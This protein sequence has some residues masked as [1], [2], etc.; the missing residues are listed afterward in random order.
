[1]V[2]RGEEAL[3]PRPRWLRA[4]VRGVRKSYL[5]PPLDR[6]RELARFIAGWLEDR[7]DPVRAP[8]VR[9]MFIVPER[10]ADHPRWPV[11][12]LH[13]LG[14]LAELLVLEPR[15]LDWLADVKRLER[16]VRD[17]RLRNYRYSWI[18]RRGGAP[19]RLIE[20]PKQRLKEIQRGLLRLI[21]E[22][23]PPHDAAH[24]FVRGRSARTHAQA[25]VGKRVVLRL[26]LE[27]FFASVQAPRIYGIFRTAGYPE[28]VAHSLTALV[29][30][31]VPAH[32]LAELP[33]S[34]DPAQWRMKNRL[35][36]S[37][38]P[39]GAPTSPALANLCA[40]RL[41]VRLAGLARSLGAT[42]TRYADDMVFSGDHRLKRAAPLVG[43]IAAAEGFRVNE[44]KTAFATRA[45]RQQVTGIVVNEQHQRRARGVR[46]PQG[47]PPQRRAQRGAARPHQLGRV[48]ESEPRREAAR[49]LPRGDGSRVTGHGFSA[50]PR[51]SPVTRHPVTRDPKVR[52]GTVYF[53][54]EPRY[55]PPH[56]SRRRPQ[57]RP[58]G[59]AQALHLH[60]G[61]RPA[62][63]I[64]PPLRREGARPA[65][66]GVGGDDVPELGLR[67][68]G[69]ARLP[70]PLLPGGVRRPGRRLLR[71]PRARRGDRPLQLRRPDDGHR[72]PHGHGD[73]AGLPVRHRGAE[74]EVP[75]AVDQGHEDLVAR[76]H[77]AGRRLRRRRHPHP[78]GPRRRRVRHQRLEDLHH[79]RHPRRLHRARHEDRPGRGLR[80]LHALPRR[81]RH[82]RLHQGEEAR[83]ARHARVRHGAARVR[84]HARAGGEHPRQGGQG[85]LPHHV[86]APGRAADRRG[87]LRRR[88]PAR[89]SR[90]RAST[91]SSARRSASRSGTSR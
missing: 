87:G 39:Q 15:R 74:A 90:R 44:R 25:H 5:R 59:P 36:D 58:R 46:P 10:M 71:E 6:P 84:R 56:D 47:D 29:T 54:R 91:R 48:A 70:R 69:R 45:G 17:E 81:H 80:R 7:T 53:S 32:V 24:G 65:R 8:S 75:G 18:P 41:D 26:D 55:R 2:R 9:R 21:L 83:E 40:F 67:A 20:S 3:D 16:T 34:P 31:A 23:I 50:I 57:A 68:D 79:E 61:A 62:T 4:A 89:C 30:N 12:E 43:Q 19:P 27:D 38:L 13:T 51:P 72:R 60:R 63:R 14:D 73:P 42:Y 28:S 22:E 33:P 76:D 64:G 78:R 86:G 37:H 1:M 49:S 85:L 66:G 88:R 35:R 82:A 77:R 52:S 11:P